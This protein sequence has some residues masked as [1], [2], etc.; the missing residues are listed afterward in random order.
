MRNN[1]I[2]DTLGIDYLRF[3]ESLDWTQIDNLEYQAHD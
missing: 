1:Q 2:K 3:L